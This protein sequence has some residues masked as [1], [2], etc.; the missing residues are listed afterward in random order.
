MSASLGNES[1]GRARRGMQPARGG[2]HAAQV[3]LGLFSRVR[4]SGHTPGNEAIAKE[5][6]HLPAL[7][8]RVTA[9]PV[10]GGRDPGLRVMLAHGA[11]DLPMRFGELADPGVLRERLP[12]RFRPRSEIADKAVFVK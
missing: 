12:E 3:C 4:Q 2:S 11:D 10:H 9:D 1:V 6:I 7:D 5:L 8:P